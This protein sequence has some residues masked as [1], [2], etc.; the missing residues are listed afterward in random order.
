MSLKRLNEESKNILYDI[1][2]NVRNEY[3]RMQF[4]WSY[5]FGLGDYVLYYNGSHEFES[6]YDFEQ[7]INNDFNLVEVANKF[8]DINCCWLSIIRN[9]DIDYD[10]DIIEVEIITNTYKLKK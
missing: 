4:M 1:L 6:D 10:S 2:Y 7:K 3:Q 5:H 8:M 9:D